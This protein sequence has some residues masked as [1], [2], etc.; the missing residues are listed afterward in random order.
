MQ[1]N[2]IEYFF[3][4]PTI[5]IYSVF[6]TYNE[7]WSKGQRVYMHIFIGAEELIFFK[8]LLLKKTYI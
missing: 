3:Y 5:I 1:Y 4:D 6:I 2:I 7:F 8:D